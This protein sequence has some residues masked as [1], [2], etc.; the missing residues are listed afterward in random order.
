[1]RWQKLGRIF[2]P[3]GQASWLATHA[4][5]PWPIH[6][7]G[8]RFR[9]LCSGRDHKGRAQIGAVELDLFDRSAAVHVDAT[10][11]LPFG[12]L[13]AFDD[14]GVLNACLVSTPEREYLYYVGVTTGGSVP[15][16]YFT[17]LALR[18]PGEPFVRYSP[19]PILERNAVDPYLTAVSFVLHDE[20]RWHMWYTSGV[21]WVLE[22]DR[23]KHYYHIKYASSSDGITWNRGGD[24]CIDFLP[25]DYAIAR[26]YVIREN[27][28]FKM[29]YCYRGGSYRIG[30]AQSE[31]GIHW[32]RMDAEVG[33]DVATEGWDSE[34]LCYPSVF[35]HA[36][37][38]Y[39]LYNGNSYGKT[40]FGLAQLVD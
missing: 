34:M 5:L 11:Y 35:D 4:M 30:Y 23:P 8:N 7:E 33:I 27:G 12:P 1:M 19:S 9:V 13:G 15:F 17:G 2:E 39:M 29:W 40:G 25:G 20:G 10:P 6:I 37:E 21:R 26:P 38:R 36:G 16:R 32:T 28:I 3:K 31:D 18:K 14:C 24:V 22:H